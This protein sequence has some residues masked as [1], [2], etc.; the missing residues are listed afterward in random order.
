[1]RLL[2]IPSSWMLIS[3]RRSRAVYNIFIVTRLRAGKRYEFLG[4]HVA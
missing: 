2:S 1:M 4:W 3:I